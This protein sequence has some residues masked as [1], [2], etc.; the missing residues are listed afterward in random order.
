[1]ITKVSKKNF[2]QWFVYASIRA[3]RTI[4]QT[5]IGA[6]GT[7]M[8]IDDINQLAVVSASVLAGIVSMLTSVTG[9]P[10]LQLD[11]QNK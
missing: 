7:S 3:A 4:S 9:L 8:F 2:R 1:M 6:I 5:I 11:N 10:E